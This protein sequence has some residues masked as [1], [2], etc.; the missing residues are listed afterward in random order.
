[1]PDSLMVHG[2]GFIGIQRAEENIADIDL[3][4]AGVELPSFRANQGMLFS[5]ACERPMKT[6]V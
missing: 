3:K 1:M 4:A 5:E 6:F 2:N